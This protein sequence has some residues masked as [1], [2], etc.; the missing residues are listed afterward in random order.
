[1]SKL[2]GRFKF[3]CLNIDS[4]YGNLWVKTSPSRTVAQIHGHHNR[5]KE[6][7]WTGC[8]QLL[9]SRIHGNG[10]FTS[11]QGRPR[12]IPENTGWIHLWCLSYGEHRALLGKNAGSERHRLSSLT[13]ASDEPWRS[14]IFSSQLATSWLIAGEDFLRVMRLHNCMARLLWGELWSPKSYVELV[15]FRISQS[16]V[17]SCDWRCIE[18][19]IWDRGY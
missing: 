19:K 1:M 18:R 11:A 3:S 10:A 7:C 9:R 14:V 5:T 2:P 15:Y 8:F 4:C 16:S 17:T 6:Q 13:A 12:R